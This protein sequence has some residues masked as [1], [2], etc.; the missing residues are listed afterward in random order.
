MFTQTYP[1]EPRLDYLKQA[2][3]MDN[4]SGLDILDMGGNNGNLLRD[5]LEVYEIHPDN[6][7]CMDVDGIVMRKCQS[8]FPEATW[9]TRTIGHHLYN[10]HNSSKDLNFSELNNKFDIIFAFSVYSHAYYDDLL[11]DLDI[12]YQCL[13]PQGKLCFT[14]IDTQS[15]KHFI[16]KR[17]NEYGSSVDLEAFEDVTDFAYFINNDIIT[18]DCVQDENYDY[19]LSVYN[20]EWLY[21][22]IKSKY[23][24]CVM[25]TNVFQP[26]FVIT[27]I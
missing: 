27:R 23:P 11:D 25:D 20:S 22:N 1:R 4:I 2:I 8:E 18:K 12:M 7:T 14:F 5:G 17:K 26:N 6:Y 19:F 10:C 9:L 3:G 21:E 24:S 15:V 16:Y 13:K